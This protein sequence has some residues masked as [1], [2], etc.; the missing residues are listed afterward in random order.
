HPIAAGESLTKGG[1]PQRQN[2][3]GFVSLM[4]SDGAFDTTWID[5]CTY[6]NLVQVLQKPP[7]PAA[8]L[9]Q[10]RLARTGSTVVGDLFP[11]YTFQGA[12][13]VVAGSGGSYPIVLRSSTGRQL[14]RYPFTP[15]WNLPD[16]DTARNVM[17]FLY[18][19]PF[20]AGTARV[21]LVG[22]GNALLG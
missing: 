9:V 12:P 3:D 2:R 16:P 4:E 11:L 20:V 19:V 18:R 14:A 17:S 7:D 13:A 22:P 1:M 10:G 8:I 5:Q 21:D 6:R 15:A